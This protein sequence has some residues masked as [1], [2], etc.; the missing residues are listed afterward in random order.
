MN[1]ILSDIEDLE[2]VMTATKN[3][4][5]TINT[6]Q[7]LEKLITNKKDEVSKFEEAMTKEFNPD[8]SA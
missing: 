8:G 1:E 5:G 7:M 6:V 4:C 2:A 3:G